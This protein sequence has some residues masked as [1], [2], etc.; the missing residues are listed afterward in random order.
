MLISKRIPRT[1]GCMG[2]KYW[3]SNACRVRDECWMK[4]DFG[5][6]DVVTYKFSKMYCRYI[7]LS[8]T[9]MM[10]IWAFP[11]SVRQSWT[12]STQL[13]FMTDP[14]TILISISKFTTQHK[15]RSHIYRQSGRKQTLQ[16]KI[17]GF[18]V[19]LTKLLVWN[20]YHPPTNSH[21]VSYISLLLLP[22]I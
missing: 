18:K 12:N 3:S 15:R 22:T 1:T 4:C 8:F 17:V 6:N 19:H 9:F 20:R 11:A 13:Q 7:T 21:K 5:H 10:T 14:H 2:N 16:L